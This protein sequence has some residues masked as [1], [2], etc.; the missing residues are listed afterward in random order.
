MEQDQILLSSVETS[1]KQTGLHIDNSKTKYNEFNQ[2]EGDLKA[3]NDFL[4]LGSLIDC[5]S[6]DVSTRI[7]KTWSAL[8]KLDTIWKPELSGVLQ[9]GFFR[10]KVE[11]VLLYGSKAWTLTQSLDKNWTGHIQKC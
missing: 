7:G 8:H 4:F 2:G 9:I 10:A 1:A 3:L 5:C 11:T 6:G